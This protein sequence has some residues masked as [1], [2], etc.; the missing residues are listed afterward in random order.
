VVPEAY[1]H[2]TPL[3]LYGYRAKQVNSDYRAVLTHLRG[4]DCLL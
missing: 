1:S 2:R 4:L 3:P